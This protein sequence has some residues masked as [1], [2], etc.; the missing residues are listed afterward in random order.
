M[1]D[2]D[3]ALMDMGLTTIEISVYKV[4]L[5]NPKI[6]VVKIAK[7]IHYYRS[8]I[9][10]ALE[11]LKDKG[12]IFEVQGKK[13]KIFEAFSPE[14]IYDS[15]KKKQKAIENAIPLLN[16]IKG[17]S[18]I[19]TQI[20]II[21][22][23]KGWKNLLDSFLDLGQERVVFGVPKDALEMEAFF[24]EY[25]KERA[26]RKISLRHIFNYEAKNRIRVTNKLPYTESKYFPKEFDQPV[27][28]S[29]CGDIVAITVYEG[30]NIQT[31]V[32]ENKMVANAYKKYF[33]LLW[34]LA[35]K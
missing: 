34:K 29:I 24:K 5:A 8:N 28:T 6:S 31:L 2:I 3:N 23:A 21:D 11:R 13:S 27:S 25:H 32:I 26:K 19:T 30:Y 22:G 33:E 4:V 1:E 17:S 18:I 15:Y 14:H 35:K 10:Q 9:Y 12:F 20:K 16:Q 7:L